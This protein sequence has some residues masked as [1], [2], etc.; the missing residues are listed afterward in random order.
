MNVC[1]PCMCYFMFFFLTVCWFQKTQNKTCAPNSCFFKKKFIKD[2]CY[3]TIIAQKKKQFKKIIESQFCHYFWHQFIHTNV[4]GSLFVHGGFKKGGTGLCVP[5][6][7]SWFVSLLLSLEDAASTISKKKLDL[8]ICHTTGQ[9]A[10]I[11]KGRIAFLD[12]VYREK[13]YR[14]NSSFSDFHRGS[15]IG[16]AGLRN[17]LS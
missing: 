10:I 9:L 13:N 14:D 7:T 8:L 1:I 6:L 17:T 4:Y 11:S 16:V 15:S 3:M 5:C 2:V 12:H